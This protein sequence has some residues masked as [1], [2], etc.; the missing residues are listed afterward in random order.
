MALSFF[1]IGFFC[2]FILIGLFKKFQKK[3]LTTNDKATPSL[4]EERENTHIKQWF[5]MLPIPAF[6]LQERGKNHL[7]NFLPTQERFYC[8]NQAARM[9]YK[10]ILLDILRHPAFFEAMQNIEKEPVQNFDISFV[11]PKNYYFTIYIERFRKYQPRP[12]LILVVIIDQSQEKYFQKIYR[13]FVANASHELRT[14]LTSLDGFIQT[15]LGPAA[16]DAKVHRQFLEIMQTQ[17]QRMIRLTDDLLALSRAEKNETLA[18]KD[19][20]SLRELVCQVLSE[21][22][23][24]LQS[25]HIDLDFQCEVENPV[26]LADHDQLLQVLHN[27]LENAVRY[28]PLGNEKPARITIR[29]FQVGKN[30]RWPNMGYVIAISD[31]GPGIAKHHLG[32]LTERFYRV[33]ESHNGTGLGLSIVKHI[34]TRHKGQLYIESD[35]GKGSCFSLFFPIEMEKA[36]EV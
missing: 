12:D 6:V 29:L 19:K 18:L 27:I 30:A 28:A 5:D 3:N 36:E 2:A 21:Q 10:D 8:I 34:M 9:N 33:E 35:V 25:K 16:N 7:S 15:L 23:I 13:D 1:L 31:N 26:I 14:P 20:V 24:K 4:L 11:I 32:R 17:V 22:Q